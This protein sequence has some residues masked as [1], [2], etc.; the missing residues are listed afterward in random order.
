MEFTFIGATAHWQ[1]AL[2]VA[3]AL[4]L[5]RTHILPSS[6]FI[7]GIVTGWMWSSI[8]RLGTRSLWAELADQS[9]CLLQDS[10]QEINT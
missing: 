7:S 9:Q 10:D 4:S 3:K 5:T 2:E 6:H 1:S 8:F